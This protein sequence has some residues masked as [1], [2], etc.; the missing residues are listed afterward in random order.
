MQVATKDQRVT[1]RK[2]PTCQVLRKEFKIT[3]FQENGNTRK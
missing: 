1:T 2:T 3:H